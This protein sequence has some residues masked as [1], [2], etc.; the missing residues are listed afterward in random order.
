MTY[1]YSLIYFRTFKAPCL[2]QMKPKA[3]EVQNYISI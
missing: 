3:S 2:L 1:L